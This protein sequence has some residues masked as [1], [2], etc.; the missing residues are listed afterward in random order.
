VVPTSSASS[1]FTS[2]VAAPPAD[3][4]H[5]VVT[6]RHQY[7]QQQ[8]RAAGTIPPSTPSTSSRR[9]SQPAA[10]SLPQLV[11]RSLQPLISSSPSTDVD[12]QSDS[13]GTKLRYMKCKQVA[14]RLSISIMELPWCWI[15]YSL[16][17]SV[18]VLTS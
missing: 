4:D 14:M 15:T 7:Q 12:D 9:N 10:F 6:S 16:R 13:V 3:P 17:R 8:T 1:F 2:C 5:S 11:R 18:C